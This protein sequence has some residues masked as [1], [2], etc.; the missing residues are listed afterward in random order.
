[1]TY[2]YVCD[3]CQ[4]EWEQEQRITEEPVKVCPQCKKQAVRRLIVSGN[5]VL[6]GKNWARDGY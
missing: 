2:V 3:A 6:K 4:L 5:F 1:M